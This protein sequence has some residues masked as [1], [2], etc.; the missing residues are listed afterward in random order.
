MNWAYRKIAGKV[1]ATVI[2]ACCASGVAAEELTNAKIIRDFNIIA[3]G[4]EYTLKRYDNVRKW[5]GPIRVGIQGKKYPA[6][7]EAYIKQHIRD[8]WEITH[9]PIEL[10]YSYVM[11]KTGELAKDFDPKK[12][13]FILFY[14]PAKDIP[15]AVA[16]YFDNDEAQVRKMIE[17]ST[18][19]AKFFTKKNVITAAI[20]VFPDHRPKNHMRACVVEELTQVLG[21]AND[22]SDVNPSIFN[23]TSPYFELTEH[24]RW[25]LKMFYDPR[26]T[27]GMPRKEAMKIG[28]T[29]L[30][31]IRPE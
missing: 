5:S 13:N 20:A 15:K 19:F 3:F 25:M 14:L 10:Y 26:I 12:V 18:C 31:E 4:N 28:R 17:V 7:F 23:D 30:D 16:K 21:L 27:A 11:Q 2:A 9:H 6:Y 29:I 22:S 1:V 8:L 24:D